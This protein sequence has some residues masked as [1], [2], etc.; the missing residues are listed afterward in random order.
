MEFVLDVLFLK[1]L[2]ECR[3]SNLKIDIRRPVRS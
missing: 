1:L 2:V 3:S